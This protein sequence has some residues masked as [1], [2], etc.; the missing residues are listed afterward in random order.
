[1]A[2][3]RDKITGKTG[4]LFGSGVLF[5]GASAWSFALGSDGRLIRRPTEGL[6]D[7]RIRD[8]EV[9][10]ISRSGDMRRT[11][12]EQRARR[13]RLPVLGICARRGGQG[14]C[15]DGGW[16]SAA[17]SSCDI[18]SAAQRTSAG[19]GHRH[20]RVSTMVA[21]T[22]LWGGSVG[23]RT[24]EPSFSFCAPRFLRTMML[25]AVLFAVSL[26]RI[27]VLEWRRPTK[28][29][30]GHVGPPLYVGTAVHRL[31]AHLGHAPPDL[32]MALRL[33]SPFRKMVRLLG[34]RTCC[35]ALP[36]SVRG[37]NRVRWRCYTAPVHRRNC[38]CN[39]G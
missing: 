18:A 6:G 26:G 8:D 2:R 9:T 5:P 38:R 27:A 16:T 35:C 11:L 32:L 22:V 25:E 3:P 20:L 15:A 14:D 12:R 31:L 36:F 13:V 17:M 28:Q 10:R 1:M 4:E 33:R 19:H 24:P 30:L 7:D 37:V 23:W 39:F 21:L 29:S 34:V